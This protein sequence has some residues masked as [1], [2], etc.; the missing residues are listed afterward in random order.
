MK[1]II[2]AIASVLISISSM[3]AQENMD[4][5]KETVA[6]KVEVNDAKGVSKVKAATEET[7]KI[8]TNGRVE[9]NDSKKAQKKKVS[10]VTAETKKIETNGRAQMEDSKKAQV[11]KVSK[12]KEVLINK[13]E[14]KAMNE[15]ELAPKAKMKKKQKSKKDNKS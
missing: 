5:K 6:K 13:D 12:E 3:T 11:Q 1:V 9:M 4:V 14:M 8:E 15:K 7:K 10:N 2:C